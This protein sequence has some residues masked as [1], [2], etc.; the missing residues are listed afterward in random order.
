MSVEI[1]LRQALFETERVLKESPFWQSSPPDSTAFNSAEPFC[2]DTMRPEQWLQWVL[3][4]RMH[5]LLDSN[6]PLPSRFSLLPYFEEALDDT[7]EGVK[8]LLFELGRLDVL[9]SGQSD[10]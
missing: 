10:A 3:L 5:R 4:P 8:P 2:I 1:Q 7:L 6:A 9:L